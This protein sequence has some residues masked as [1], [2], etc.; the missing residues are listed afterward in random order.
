MGDVNRELDIYGLACGKIRYN[1]EKKFPYKHYGTTSVRKHILDRHRA[2]TQ[3]DDVSK[4]GTDSVRKIDKLIRETIDAGVVNYVEN[5]VVKVFS[6]N[7]GTTSFGVPTNKIKVFFD[8]K[9]WVR[10]AFPI[11]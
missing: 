8:S 1:P 4:F 7:I 5:S 10:T 3:F 11:S 6:R 9:G 2:S